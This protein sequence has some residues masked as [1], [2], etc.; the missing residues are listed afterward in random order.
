MLLAMPWSRGRL[1]T[2]SKQGTQMT[3]VSGIRGSIATKV[4]R[5]PRDE[6]PARHEAET[7][8]GRALIPLQPIAPSDTPLRTRPQAAYLA[9]LIATK[10][11]LPQTRERRRAEPQDVIAAYAAAIAGPAAPVGTTLFRLS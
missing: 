10:D 6:T 9:H 11:K 3:P 8:S 4:G 2:G 7:A 1:C 5:A